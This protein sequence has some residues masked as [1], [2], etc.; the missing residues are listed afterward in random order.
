MHGRIPRVALITL[1]FIVAAGCGGL[2]PH[3]DLLVPQ[4][5]P[6]TKRAHGINVTYLGC[7][8]FL[9]ESPTTKLL[10]DPFFSRPGLGKVAFGIPIS[11]DLE[12][13][14]PV[15]EQLPGSV[16][17]I[18]ITHAHYDHLMD[19]PTVRAKVGGRLIASKTSFKLIDAGEG[20]SEIGDI[21]RVRGATIHVLDAA[22]DTLCGFVPFPGGFD[23]IHELP[24]RKAS[25]YVCGQP[26]AFL[27]EIDGK[28]IYIESGGTLDVLPPDRPQGT[29][30][31]LLGTA[32]NDSQ[33]RFIPALQR[34][35]PRITFPSHQDNFFRPLDKP[36]RFNIGTRMRRIRNDFDKA[37]IDGK[38]VLLDFFDSLTLE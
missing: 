21:I 14:N 15:L 33:T 3:R 19:V 4:T 31:A 38:L 9:I 5:S 27:I 32:L 16:D 7:N 37:G 29:D 6:A 28:S 22:H 30:L 24:P 23:D 17:A 11:T 35:R 10:I 2:R 8:A 20:H 26:F 13:V 25:D 12:R 34:L 1:A 18:L 36:Y